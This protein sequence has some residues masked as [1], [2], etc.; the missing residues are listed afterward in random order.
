MAM[1]WQ[2]LFAQRNISTSDRKRI[3]I[4][5]AQLHRVFTRTRLEKFVVN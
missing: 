4:I 2:L 3:R 1:E 5:S